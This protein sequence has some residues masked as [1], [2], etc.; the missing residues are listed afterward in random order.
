[1]GFLLAIDGKADY[2]PSYMVHV[3]RRSH[4]WSDLLN[5]SSTGSGCISQQRLLNSAPFRTVA[6]GKYDVHAGHC[7]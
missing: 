1:M 5:C 3:Q 4:A 6:D 7:F 2:P